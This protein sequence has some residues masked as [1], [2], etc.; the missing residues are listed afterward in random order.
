MESVTNFL[1]TSK[2]VMSTST[3]PEIQAVLR[4]LATSYEAAH[5]GQRMP[6][7]QR[8]IRWSAEGWE[9]GNCGVIGLHTV[10]KLAELHGWKEPGGSDGGITQS[11]GVRT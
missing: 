4:L 5:F 10:L 2:E 7:L 3:R 1:A 8:V 9:V 11:K 6:P